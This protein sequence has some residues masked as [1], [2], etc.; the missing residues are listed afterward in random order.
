MIRSKPLQR[1]TRIQAVAAALVT[2]SAATATAQIQTPDI[3]RAVP[4]AAPGTAEAAPRLKPLP[5]PSLN[6]YGV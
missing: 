1:S 3:T 5:P 6:F 2:L 4:N